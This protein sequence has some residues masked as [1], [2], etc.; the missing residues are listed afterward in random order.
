[1]D[2]LALQQLAQEKLGSRLQTQTQ[3][4]AV[5]PEPSATPP[6]SVTQCEG[7]TRQNTRCRH[8]PGPGNRYCSQHRDQAPPTVAAAAPT[9][10]STRRGTSPRKPPSIP[11]FLQKQKTDTSRNPT[12]QDVEEPTVPTR[13][14]AENIRALQDW[15]QEIRR[16]GITA[17]GALRS[18]SPTTLL[19]ASEHGSSYTAPPPTSQDTQVEDLY[20]DRLSL[21]P[22]QEAE[23]YPV[24]YP[25]LPGTPGGGAAQDPSMDCDADDPQEILDQI[26]YLNLQMFAL[27]QKLQDLQRRRQQEA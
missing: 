18:E 6:T 7:T 9:S 10:S 23:D 16:S 15:S 8:A 5:A 3:A 20:V 22:G 25:P 1:M 14:K 24:F 19:N 21:E 11:S 17:R 12:V 4:P 13:A 2:R 26:E 27:L